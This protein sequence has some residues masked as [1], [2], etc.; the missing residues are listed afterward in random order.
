MGEVGRFTEACVWEGWRGI[1]RYNQRVH[2]EQVIPPT[3]PPRQIAYKLSQCAVLLDATY[4][5]TP[6]PFDPK[7][8]SYLYFFQQWVRISTH[9]GPKFIP[10][11]GWYNLRHPVFPNM[12]IVVSEV[13][14]RG[15]ISWVNRA[16]FVDRG[17]IE[18]VYQWIA[19]VET[20]ELPTLR[21]QLAL[22]TQY[23]EQKGLPPEIILEKYDI[24]GGIRNMYNP[25]S[26]DWH[27]WIRVMYM[28]GTRDCL[29]ATANRIFA[30][31]EEA[32]AFW[33]ALPPGHDQK[34]LAKRL[35]A[36]LQ[37]A[38]SATLRKVVRK[39]IFGRK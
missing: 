33:S 2:H 32:T 12:L 19:S 18:S 4:S 38:P 8:I 35:S 11:E 21:R 27:R 16:T 14:Q 31:T 20:R 10:G 30:T 17:Q 5:S 22:L 13:A 6:L 24:T 26:L 39:Q 36:L 29:R 28:V 37:G 3:S 7:Y 23:T 34:L 9:L 1:C 15:W 25:P